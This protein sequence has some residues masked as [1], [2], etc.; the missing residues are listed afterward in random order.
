MTK[1]KLIKAGDERVLLNGEP[2]KVD[3]RVVAEELYQRMES[4]QHET[5]VLRLDDEVAKKLKE[6]ADWEG[7]AVSDYLKALMQKTPFVFSH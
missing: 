1:P 6:R 7:M 3:C 5:L 2:P 4:G